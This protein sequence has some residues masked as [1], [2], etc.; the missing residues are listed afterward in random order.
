MADQIYTLKPWQRDYAEH[1][2]LP[3]RVGVKLRW[4]RPNDQ[5]RLVH[6]FSKLSRQSRQMRCFTPKPKLT[7]AE[8][9]F[10]TRFRPGEHAALCALR[11]DQGTSTEAEG[12][13]A[14]RYVRLNDMPN[15]VELAFTVVD[16]WQG[17]GIGSLLVQRLVLV[18]QHFGFEEVH[19][20][21]YTSNTAV[22][23]LLTRQL[24]PGR[25]S[26]AGSTTTGVFSLASLE[27]AA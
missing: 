13:G 20:H 23:R 16:A 5:Q 24:G 19:A 11:W 9:E 2:T 22:R 1:V 26:R 17:L 25:Y 4:L 3:D 8:L 14:A 6:A 7:V 21:W 18:L 27:R 12:I 10:F 15:A